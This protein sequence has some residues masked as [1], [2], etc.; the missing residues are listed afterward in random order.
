LILK[1]P[2]PFLIVGDGGTEVEGL[3]EVEGNAKE[4]REVLPSMEGERGGDDGGVPPLDPERESRLPPP[5]FRSPN[6]DVDEDVFGR[7]HSLG[8]GN[9]S[10]SAYRRWEMTPFVCQSCEARLAGM[11]MV[12]SNLASEH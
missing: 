3:A 12:K 8:S 9:P 7:L 5:V 1:A 4:L 11:M 6:S 2:P 10:I